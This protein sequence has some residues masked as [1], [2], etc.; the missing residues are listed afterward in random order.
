MTTRQSSRNRIC[1]SRNVRFQT[2]T[3]LGSQTMLKVC[4]QR[5][6]QISCD[7]VLSVIIKLRSAFPTQEDAKSIIQFAYSRVVYLCLQSFNCA[8]KSG[9]VLIL[10]RIRQLQPV[11]DVQIMESG[12]K[13]RVG[14]LETEKKKR[15][16]EGN[17]FIPLPPLSLTFFM[18]TILYAFPTNCRL[19]EV[20][21]TEIANYNH[22]PPFL[23]PSLENS[24]CKKERKTMAL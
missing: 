21:A 1:G 13:W 12:G 2:F 22:L 15:E 10:N 14:T 4:A 11:P 7:Q 6:T 8:K 17:T 9:S 16:R 24:R 20:T 5:R 3:D 23:R 19:E 18:L